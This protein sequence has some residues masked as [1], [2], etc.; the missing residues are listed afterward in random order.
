MTGYRRSSSSSSSSETGS[1]ISSAR[2]FLFFWSLFLSSLLHF[3][4]AFSTIFSTS[5]FHFFLSCASI[6]RSFSS[7]RLVSCVT[8]FITPPVSLLLSSLGISLSSSSNTLGKFL[9]T[10]ACGFSR[11]LPAIVLS[12]LG[13][14]SA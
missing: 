11:F 13:I 3:S 6:L 12:P 8:P 7:F 5:V 10:P 1:G 2:L 9:Y 14:V 4:S